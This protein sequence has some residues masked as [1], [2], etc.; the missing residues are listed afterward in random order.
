MN[1]LILL[2]DRAYLELIIDVSS[3]FQAM[4]LLQTRITGISLKAINSSKAV[5][6]IAGPAF[7]KINSVIVSD[8]AVGASV[9]TV[10][11][12]C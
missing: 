5:L 9:L 8:S 11:F 1:S 12:F 6:K 4:F 10:E 7:S 2:Q 3:N